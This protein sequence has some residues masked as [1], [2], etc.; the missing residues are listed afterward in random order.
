MKATL[1]EVREILEQLDQLDW[2]PGQAKKLFEMAVQSKAPRDQTQAILEGGFWSDLLLG[3]LDEVNREEFRRV[4]GLK[5][6]QRLE[7]LRHNHSHAR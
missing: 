7:P 5:P 6:L 1:E 4:L 3:D 2:T